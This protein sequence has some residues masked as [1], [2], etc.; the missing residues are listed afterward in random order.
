[1]ALSPGKICQLLINCADQTADF[2]VSD[3][4][5]YARVGSEKYFDMLVCDLFNTLI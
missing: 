5:G 3:T 1:M 2:E 4:E